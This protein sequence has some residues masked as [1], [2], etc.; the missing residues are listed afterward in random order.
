MWNTR[1]IRI[2]L[3]IGLQIPIVQPLSKK[4]LLQTKYG[5]K[6]QKKKKEHINYKVEA[7]HK[8]PFIPFKWFRYTVMIIGLGVVCLALIGYCQ[9]KKKRTAYDE[10]NEIFILE[11]KSE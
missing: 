6:K 7:K 2:T 10:K 1:R 3:F 11:Q 5:S 9:Q 4:S 8:K